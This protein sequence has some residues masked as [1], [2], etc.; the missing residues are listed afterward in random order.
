MKW[1]LALLGAVAAATCAW[2]WVTLRPPEPVQAPPQQPVLVLPPL[3]PNAS[4]TVA[5]AVQRA[6]DP[7][8]DPQALRSVPVVGRADAE[9]GFEAL[10]QTLEALADSRERLS[11]AR[12]DELYRNVNDAF[13][14]LSA[15]LDPNDAADMQLLE[16]AN[17]RMK[18]MLDELNIRV[19]K[20][21]PV[22]P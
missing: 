16:D 14:G 17:I 7:P 3:S 13:S 11:R 12:R 2:A 6:I 1:R 15:T 22:A 5:D 20:R 4:R 10:M 8:P 19:P 9:A 21:P 18:A